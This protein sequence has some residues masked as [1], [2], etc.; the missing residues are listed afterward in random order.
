MPPIEQRKKRVFCKFHGYL[1]HNTSRCVSFRDS[2]QKV[3][4]EGR[5]KFGN[6]SNKPMQKDADP[7]K[8]AD[9]MYVEIVDV[10]V[11]ETAESVTESVTESFGKPKNAN[12]YQKRDVE[13]VT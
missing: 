3:L 5:L 7:L 10:N 11:I 1:G 4:D 13:M 6:K 12:N 8:Q 9:S 2:V